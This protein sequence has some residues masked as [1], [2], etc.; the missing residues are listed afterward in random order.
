[1]VDEEI[2]PRVYSQ[3]QDAT[4]EMPKIDKMTNNGRTN[5]H[6]INNNSSS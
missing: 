6:L 2:K 1:M 3:L 4:T 5:H